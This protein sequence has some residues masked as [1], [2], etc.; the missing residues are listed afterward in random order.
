MS[1]TS[2]LL[3]SIGDD[4]CRGETVSSVATPIEPHLLARSSNYGTVAWW[5][6]NYDGF[7]VTDEQY[8]ALEAMTWGVAPKEI[9]RFIK[10]RG[11]CG[12]GSKATPNST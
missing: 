12:S 4:V 2:S 5:E 7:G 8:E 9:R 6:E 11:N 3:E 10:R 1:S